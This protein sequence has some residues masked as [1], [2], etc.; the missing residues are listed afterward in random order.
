MIEQFAEKNIIRQYTG[1]GSNQARVGY[2]EG[3]QLVGQVMESVRRE[4]ESCDHVSGFQFTHSLGGNAGSGLGSLI[5]DK[6]RSEYSECVSMSFSV[7]P[8]PD[9]YTKP[10]EPYNTLLGLHQFSFN[11]NLICL[12][13]KA[14]NPS[15][16]DY[17]SSTKD[18][19]DFISGFTS[20]HRFP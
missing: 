15:E 9:F 7:I 5:M 14:L 10:V 16:T 2:T 3:S 17:S 11:T 12:I 4:V 6:L 13:D 1:A 18:I 19:V 20:I 8:R